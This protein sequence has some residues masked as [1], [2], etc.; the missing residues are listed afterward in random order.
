MWGD[1]DLDLGRVKVWDARV[2]AQREAWLCAW[3]RAAGGDPFSHPDWLRAFAGPDEDPLCAHLRGLDDEE[4]LHAFVRRPITADACG[5]PVEEGLSDALTVLL[6]GGPVAQRSSEALRAAFQRGFAAWAQWTGL[7][8]EFVRMSPVAERRLPYPGRVREQAPHVVRSL[9]AESLDELWADLA[10]T[11]RRGI[12]K[13][14]TAGLTAAV[15]TDGSRLDDFLRIYG[16]TMD[17][18]GS[19]DRFRFPRETFEQIHRSLGDRFAY[20]YAEHEG[21]P[22]AVDLMLRSD[23]TGYFFLGGALTDALP[24]HASAFVH[25][26]AIARARGAGLTDYVLTGGVTNTREDSLLRFKRGFAPRGE[27]LYLTG[28]QIFD[29]DAYARLQCCAVDD[30]DAAGGSSEFFPAYRAPGRAPE[31]CRR[32]SRPLLTGAV[33]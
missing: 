17:R 21:R 8:T 1:R 27:A 18:V 22:V 9:R 30:A 11:A 14:R 4:L 2:P 19:A 33:A 10:S 20:V 24:L 25:W 26:E 31:E 28:E 12:R 23:T 3:E 15:D 13:A 29:A 32:R 7:V 6:Y 16:E 5:H